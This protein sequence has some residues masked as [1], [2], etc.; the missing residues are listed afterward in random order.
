MKLTEKDTEQIQTSCKQ[1]NRSVNID[2]RTVTG[3]KETIISLRYEK[4]EVMAGR[5]HPFPKG[6]LYIPET[7]LLR[8]YHTLMSHLNDYDYFI[9]G[10]L[11]MDDNLNVC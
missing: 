1:P 3:T 7:S 2:V 9:C 5:K 4:K 10:R 8:R 11:Y 6:I